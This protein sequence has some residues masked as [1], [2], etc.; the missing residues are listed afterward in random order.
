MSRPLQHDDWRIKTRV[1]RDLAKK[2]RH[3][4]MLLKCPARNV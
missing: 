4:V 1:L 2:A 3:L